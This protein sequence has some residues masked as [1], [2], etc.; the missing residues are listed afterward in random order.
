MV[1][2]KE[3]TS[4][5]IIK[6]MLDRIDELA[7]NYRKEKTTDALIEYIQF[8]DDIIKL[9]LNLKFMNLYPRTNDKTLWNLTCYE[10]V[11]TDELKIFHNGKSVPDKTFVK[12]LKEWREKFDKEND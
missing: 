4:K 1:K 3:V 11:V 10:V 7:E 6:N 2:F 8:R 5:N 9:T 12:E